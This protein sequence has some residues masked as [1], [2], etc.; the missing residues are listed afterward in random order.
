MLNQTRCCQVVP[1]GLDTACWWVCLAQQQQPDRR[2][3]NV[4]LVSY[5]LGGAMDEEAG[6]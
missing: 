5:S 2:A 4:P 3:D 1:A 6:L